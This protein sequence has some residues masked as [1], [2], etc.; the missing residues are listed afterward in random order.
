MHTLSHPMYPYYME[1][2]TL[3]VEDGLR[4]L[5]AMLRKAA[6]HTRFE[7][8]SGA[9]FMTVLTIYVL[10]LDMYNVYILMCGIG[11]IAASLTLLFTEHY[12]MRKLQALSGMIGN[13]LIISL[14]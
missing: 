12:P 11:C 4:Q 1:D 14:L 7:I 3:G 6:R 13:L 5:Y 10:T 2:F 9:L 8:I